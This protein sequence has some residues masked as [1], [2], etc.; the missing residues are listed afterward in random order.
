MKDRYI[1]GIA[2]GIFLGF[3]VSIVVVWTLVDAPDTVADFVSDH[4]SDAVTLLAAALALLGISKQIQS[5]FD[6]TEKTRL[7]KLDA[8]RATLPIVL[9]NIHRLAIERMYGIAF[10]KAQPA[11]DTK[12]N[13]SEAELAI[14]KDCIEHADGIEK[15][16]M[17]DI[18]RI[19][20]VFIVRWENL[21][22][23][24]LFSAAATPGENLTSSRLKQFREITNW[25]V[26]K[27]HSDALFNYARGARS[28]PSG[29]AMK[30]DV[31]RTLRWINSGGRTEVGGK[32][33]IDN[34]HFNNFVK[35]LEDSRNIG[36]IFEDWE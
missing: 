3:V 32:M 5:N 34:S 27:S 23:E 8:A 24:D 12:W 30:D 6:L 11:S 26:L 17:L 35:G 22:F 14:L 19:Y 9:S 20:Q 13:I 29:D 7:A 28:E 10:G 2:L 36:F 25:A 4:I 31:I 15:R 21:D 18:C 1:K 33:L 16:L